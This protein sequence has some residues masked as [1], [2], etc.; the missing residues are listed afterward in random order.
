MRNKTLFFKKLLLCG[1]ACIALI[2]TPVSRSNA[3]AALFILIF[4]DK[5]ASEKFHL[6]MDIGANISS[7]NGLNDGKSGIGPNFGL[8]THL[9]LSDEWFFVGEFKPL[10]QKGARD[11]QNPIPIPSELTAIETNSNLKLNYLELPLL[12]Q[13]RFSNGFYFSAGPQLSFL[14]SANQKTEVTL[15]TG[16]IVNIDQDIEDEFEGM[17]FSFPVE[18][19]YAIRSVRQEKGMDIRL[20]YT[21]GFGEVFKE[22]TSRSANFSTIQFIVTFPFVEKEEE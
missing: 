15:S 22:S 10:S 19:A 21:Q 3:Q 20:R 2:S 7:L 12:M 17:D 6:S 4:G 14:M 16:T 13:Y 8:G 11:V 18:I 5:V 1:I 9:K